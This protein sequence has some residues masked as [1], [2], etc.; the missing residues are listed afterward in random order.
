MKNLILIRHAKS[1]GKDEFLDDRERP[2]NERG[3]REACSMGKR[4]KTLHIRPDLI[5]ASPARRARKTAERIA[6]EVGYPVR[7]IVLSD[8]AYMAGAAGLADL[9]H[10]ADDGRACIFLVGHNPDLTE[11]ANRLADQPVGDLPTCG[12]VSLE[13]P[14]TSWKDVGE[15]SGHVA[16]VDFP[17]NR[18]L[19]PTGP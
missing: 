18:S 15:G 10:A 12:I 5:L 7:E 3:K 13:F 14:T 4:L 16:F 9:I 2:L 6:R 1:S 17:K 19:P 11:L 8:A